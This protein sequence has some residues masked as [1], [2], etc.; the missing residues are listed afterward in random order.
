MHIL[1]FGSNLN[2]YSREGCYTVNSVI[3]H[4]PRWTPKCM[5]YYRVWVIT[6]MVYDRVDCTW[7]RSIF[8][9]SWSESWVYGIEASKILVIS[10]NGSTKE[11]PWHEKENVQA[12]YVMNIDRHYTAVDARFDFSSFIG[13][14]P[15]SKQGS[16][17]RTN[18][19]IGDDYG[20]REGFDSRPRFDRNIR[21]KSPLAIGMERTIRHTLV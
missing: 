12:M 14:S 13:F 15:S 5:G 10:D 9:T 8:S 19:R 6:M 20:L 2:G 7:T 11:L 17:G 16:F 3:T 18:W 1:P 21:R 4:T